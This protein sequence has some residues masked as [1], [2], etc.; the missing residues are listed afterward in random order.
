MQRRTGSKWPLGKWTHLQLKSVYYSTV[1]FAA[2]RLEKQLK[3]TNWAEEVM[4]LLIWESLALS[5]FVKGELTQLL[6]CS[7][8]HPETKCSAIQMGWARFCSLS[9]SLPVSFNTLAAVSAGCCLVTVTVTMCR[10]CF[11][12]WE[13][14]WLNNHFCFAQNNILRRRNQTSL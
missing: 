6:G 10:W 14:L 3:N 5:F 7:L 13:S 11:T 8:R 1:H 4:C 9:L 2:Q 12:I